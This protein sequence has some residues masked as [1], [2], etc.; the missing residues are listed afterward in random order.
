VIWGIYSEPVNLYQ[1]VHNLEHGGV[2]IQYGDQVPEADIRKI[3]TFYQDDP[4]AMLVAPLPKLGDKI[5]LTAWTHL[6]E[7]KHF[8]ESAFKAF[9]S[10]FRYHAPE[11][12]LL[13]KSQLNPG[14]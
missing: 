14:S 1:E 11:S 5:A 13:T 2:I 10:A 4:N 8:N 6:A 12:P 7:G 3:E 9:R